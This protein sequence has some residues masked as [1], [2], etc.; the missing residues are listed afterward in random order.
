MKLLDLTQDF[1]GLA[2]DL[3]PDNVRFAKVL[4][5]PSV[6]Q[7]PNRDINHVPLNPRTETYDDLD[8][9]SRSLIKKTINFFE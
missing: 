9:R 3:L 1:R 4:G 5:K 2:G 7:A 8:A 6:G